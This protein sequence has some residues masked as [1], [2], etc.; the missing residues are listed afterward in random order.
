MFAALED[1]GFAP[2]LIIAACGGSIATSIINSFSVNAARKAYLQSE[3]LYKFVKSVKLTRERKLY[4]IGWYSLKK[5]RTKKNAPYI[6]N[7]FDRYLVDMPQN[8]SSEL[9]SLSPIMGLN[10]SS[11]IIGSQ[12]LF[13][14]LDSGKE[15]K[16]KKLYRKVLFTDE[17]TAEKINCKNIEIQSENYRSEAIDPSVK[18]MVNVPML[19]AMRISVS[20]M[21]Y[22]QPVYYNNSYFAGGAIDLI[23]L[24]LARSISETVI[25]EKKS[26]YTGIEESLVRAVL[27]YSGNERLRDVEKSDV[28]YWID[29]TDATYRL[30]GH[31]CK[32]NID[33]RRLQ[34]D[35]SLPFSYGQFVEDMH[36]QWQYGYEKIM[37][38][39][40]K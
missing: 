10:I 36:I 21:F 12:I 38:G 29:T 34:V 3:E 30:N 39:L 7:V 26:G 1:S 28:D 37:K 14:P 5:M 35:I 24:E 17:K 9:P 27:G 11:I 40:E 31:Y 32:K 16:D 4:R 15:R 20:D 6:E 8:L 2:D 22:V 13:N 18:V 33:W 25:L 19:T 23:P